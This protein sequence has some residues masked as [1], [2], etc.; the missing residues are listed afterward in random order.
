MGRWRVGGEGYVCGGVV[1]S[2][3]SNRTSPTKLLY[4]HTHLASPN[5]LITVERF[6]MNG[7]DNCLFVARFRNVPFALLYLYFNRDVP[8]NISPLDYC[9][10]A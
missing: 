2:P 1:Q 5:T 7:C 10:E 4:P 8:G 6:K 9:Q 3:Q